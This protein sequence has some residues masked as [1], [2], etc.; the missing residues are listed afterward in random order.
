MRIFFGLIFLFFVT[1]SC[2]ILGSA[3]NAN[4][5]NAVI[6]KNKVSSKSKANSYNAIIT[7]EAV[8]QQGLFTVHRVGN[9]HYFEIADSILNHEILVVT[10]FVKTPAGAGNY[11][12]EEIGKKTII[13]EKGPENKL[14]LR[15]GTLVSMADENDAIS[16]AVNNSNIT[17]ILEAFEIKARHEK[18]KTSVID[19]TE[20]INSENTLLALSEPQKESYKLSSL[21]KDKS[22]IEK[23]T[24]FP[25]NTEVRTVK[26]YKAKT[27]SKS[28]KELPAAVLSGVVT[29]E[30]N[31]SFIMLPKE[32]MKKRFFD[33]RV[34]YFASSYLEYGDEQQK[35]DRNTFIHRWRLE[36]KPEDIEKWE[37]G[38]LVEPKKPIVFYIDPATPKKWRPFLIQGINDWQK[39]FEQAG[40]KNAIVGQEWPEENTNMSLE[41]ARFSVLRY[42]ASPKKNAYGPNI[43][44][45]RSGEILESHIGWYHNLMNLLHSWYT[46]QAGA[47]DQRAQS[48]EFEPEL[49]GELIRFVSSHEVGHTLGL[50]HNMG[51]SYATPVEKLRDA[52]WL[53][54][55]GHTSSIMDY[56]RFNYV[57]QPQDSIPPKDLMPRIGD[58]D[59]WAIQWGYGKLPRTQELADEREILNQWV[60]DSIS[61]NPRLWFGGEGRDFDPRSQTEDLGDNAMVAS[62]YGI[63]NLQRIVPKLTDWTKARNSDDYSNLDEIYENLV[64]QYE[65]YLFHVAKNIGGIYVTPKT[66]GESGEVYCPVPKNQ[67]KEA[68]VFLN[69]HIF[70][71]PKWLINNE[72]L[73]KTSS[74][75]SK[76]SIT[77]TMERVLL[78]LMGGSRM[79]R[80]T[81]I[82]ERYEDEDV[83]APD[84]YIDDLNQLIWG[85]MN[86]FYK[87]DSYRRKLQKAYV[88]NMITLYKPSEAE[89]LVE[90]ILAKM[91]EGY[92]SNTDVRSLALHNLT[93]LQRKIKG[94]IPVINHRMTKAHLLYIQ[95]EIEEV[96]GETKDPGNLFIPANPDLAIDKGEEKE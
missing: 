31:S 52:E 6:N 49:M 36:P 63:M 25:I 58:Y 24:S 83:Y 88:S 76:E 75:Q 89:G 71:E 78:N 22:Y 4:D 45:P 53:R 92:T 47:V 12:G 70:K 18:K 32:P 67:Q 41:D 60:V 65:N 95:K 20:F 82:N 30:L 85:E 2:S 86:V 96:I 64:K 93:M 23:I 3:K 39:A 62:T 48:M 59:K 68:L 61:T 13:W 16:E 28:K 87:T 90:G 40:F 54:K 73:N 42:F 56:A 46:I 50:R 44:D 27:S 91:S 5:P 80:M 74:P 17:P 26:T 38:E 19:V 77:K 66:M 21:E 9:K 11:G 79:S 15:I 37:N 34:G 69:N 51:A 84:E 57:A 10:R 35:V 94:T 8:S 43:T 33:E 72:I 55:N 7:D 81:F 29:L 1:S 14:F